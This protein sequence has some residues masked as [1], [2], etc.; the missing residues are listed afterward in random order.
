M[1]SAELSTT[2][3]V[4]RLCVMVWTG[5]DTPSEEAGGDNVPA[6][7]SRFDLAMTDADRCKPNRAARTAPD[8]SLSLW[9]VGMVVGCGLLSAW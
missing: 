1:V 3:E 6:K 9:W 4:P 2:R 5:D 8:G 7:I